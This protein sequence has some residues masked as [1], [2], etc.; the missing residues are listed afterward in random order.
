[1]RPWTL[2]PTATFLHPA[3]ALA[4]ADTP[5]GKRGRPAPLRR[6]SLSRRP[7]RQQE[8]AARRLGLE[9]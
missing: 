7:V 5:R 2:T 3:L 4:T 1:V 9:P 6:G 8:R